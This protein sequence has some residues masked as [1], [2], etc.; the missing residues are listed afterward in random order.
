MSNVITIPQLSRKGNYCYS[1]YIED[2]GFNPMNIIN[3]ANEVFALNLTPNKIKSEVDPLKGETPSQLDQDY[4]EVDDTPLPEEDGVLR[5]RMPLT[6]E[7]ANIR[8]S[9]KTPAF[10]HD[11]D[12]P[13]HP[14]VSN[15]MGY[16]PITEEEAFQNPV[17]V[18]LLPA[19]Y[20]AVKRGRMT[21]AQIID[22]IQTVIFQTNDINEIAPK[23]KTNHRGLYNSNVVYT[24][25]DE[26]ENHR[27]SR[28]SIQV[29]AITPLKILNGT[30]KGV[31]SRTSMATLPINE[32]KKAGIYDACHILNLHRCKNPNELF[33][34]VVYH[35]QGD[36][37]ISMSVFETILAYVESNGESNP[38]VPT[39]DFSK[40]FSDQYQDALSYPQPEDITISEYNDEE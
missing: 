13:L 22:L 24:T 19:C 4:Y 12:P 16:Q 14:S 5:L 39:P 37:R 36:S 31:P 33:A 34:I 40:G 8:M 26:Y 28:M 10:E 7:E 29:L 11:P 15:H 20:F 30:P 1:Q 35:T 6:R 25:F 9:K 18:N 38:H 27:F 21:I 2:D 17:S 32:L 23:T 3:E